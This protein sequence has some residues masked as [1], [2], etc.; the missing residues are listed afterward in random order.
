MSSPDP[1]SPDP[2][3]TDPTAIVT[4]AEPE[5]VRPNR[6]PQAIS[7]GFL[8]VAAALLWIASR[9]TWS[10]VYAEDGLGEPR[11]YA[12]AGSDWSPWLVAIALLFLAGL[13]VQFALHGFF[14]RVVAALVAVCAVVVAVPAIT[15]LTNGQDSGY[16]ID[17]ADIGARYEVVAVTA[18]NNAGIVALFGAFFGVVGAV[19]MASA[20]SGAKKMSSR[21]ASPAAR[22]EELE[23]RV[24]A[25]HAQAQAD[26]D[27]AAAP[28]E[29][30]FWDALDEGVD[31][32]DLH[33]GADPDAPRP[34]ETRG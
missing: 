12:I 13:V 16:A 25:E 5:T 3:S 31:P 32:T 14:L 27:A 1:S 33:G 15:L 23:R 26:G 11:I 9:M 34:D 17:R 18:Y 29:R 19:A 30:E 10:E 8:V 7:A 4:P 6:R 21:Y 24:F 28:T 20:A 2:S 22:R